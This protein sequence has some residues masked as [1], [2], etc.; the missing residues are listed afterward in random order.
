VQPLSGLREAACQHI[1]SETQFKY[2][3]LSL[4][5]KF[6]CLIFVAVSVAVAEASSFS[7][8][9]STFYLLYILFFYFLCSYNLYRSYISKPIQPIVI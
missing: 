4:I 7:G 8:I 3:P 6:C 5:S 9:S 2:K 1:A